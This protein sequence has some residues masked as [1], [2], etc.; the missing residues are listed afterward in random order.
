MTHW[1]N[2]DVIFSGLATP[3]TT[4]TAVVP[5]A[6]VALIKGTPTPTNQLDQWGMEYNPVAINEV[7]AYSYRYVPPGKTSATAQANRFFMELVNTQ[8]APE[9][10]TATA[11]GFNPVVDL[12]GYV[13]NPVADASV[14]GTPDPYTGAPWDIIFTGDDPYSRPDPYR[15]QLLPYANLYAATP[16]SQAS[17]GP[18]PALATGVTAVLNNPVVAAGGTGGGTATDGFDVMLQPLTWNANTGVANRPDIQAPIGPGATMASGG[19]SP[20][21]VNYFYVIG[22]APPTGSSTTGGTTTTYQYEMG[23]PSPTSAVGG[24]STGTINNPTAASYGVQVTAVGTSVGT[25]PSQTQTFKSTLTGSAYSMDPMP[26]ATAPPP[27]TA[28]PP[29]PSPISLYAGVLPAQSM[30]FPTTSTVPNPSTTT[31]AAQLPD[32]RAGVEQPGHRRLAQGRTQPASTSG[33]ACGGRPI[34]LLR[35]R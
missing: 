24:V 28:P 22:N 19:T 12:G 9:V 34:C 16:L 10:G 27:T 35:F 31:A 6:A 29:V 8:T 25:L 26:S 23:S 30:T 33:C 3:T 32:D 20:I 11:A 21:P 1:V 5:T 18:P 2:P 4:T 17:F 14:S 15:G 7:L 13:Y